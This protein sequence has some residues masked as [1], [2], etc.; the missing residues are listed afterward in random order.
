LAVAGGRKRV[1]EGGSVTVEEE[2]QRDV[3]ALAGGTQRERR[4]ER[5]IYITVKD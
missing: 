5:E 3:Q 2:R 4:R 1:E